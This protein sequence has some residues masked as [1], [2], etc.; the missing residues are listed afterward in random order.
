MEFGAPGVTLTDA[1]AVIYQSIFGDRMPLPLDHTSS[2]AVTG[3]IQP[4][5]HP[6][7]VVNVAIGQSTWVSQRVKANIFYRGLSLLRPVYIGDTLRTRTRIVA[8][9]R[10][11]PQP[12]R[13]DTGIVGLEIV[14]RNQHDEI[15]LHF[16]RCPMIACRGDIP[17]IERA[18]NLDSL[19]HA[20]P[21]PPIPD[22]HFQHMPVDY[23]QTSTTPGTILRVEARDTV[24]AA[25][26]FV[27]LTLNMAMAHTDAGHSHLGARLVYG[28]HTISTCF[29]QLTRAL[30]QMAMLLSWERCDHL[31]PVIEGDRLRSEFTIVEAS[32]R[33][34]VEVLTVRAQ[35]FA[36]RGEPETESAVLDWMFSVLNAVSPLSPK[37]TG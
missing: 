2:K 8:L 29:A 16:W 17:V 14:T 24:T 1:H 4:L 36:A 3:N 11:R 10:N 34:R 37:R 25:P 32:P 20:A 22:W 23:G 30:P 21:L 7:L 15:V 28:G 18:D 33:G 12:G 13:P 27:R 26:E 31:A 19:G 35:C 6:L 5:A 9:R